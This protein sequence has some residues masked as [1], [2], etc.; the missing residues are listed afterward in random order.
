MNPTMSEMPNLTLKHRSVQRDGYTWTIEV[1]ENKR[2]TPVNRTAIVKRA[3]SV[4]GCVQLW[5][6]GKT[7]VIP[8]WPAQEFP[9]SVLTD[10]MK[11]LR[12]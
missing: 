6:N 2:H 8:L 1:V 7:K 4:W 12:G 11:D 10:V 3:G 5:H 9:D